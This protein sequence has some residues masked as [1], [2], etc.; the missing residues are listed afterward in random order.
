MRRPW[1]RLRYSDV[2][3]KAVYLDRRR[4]MAGAA[5]LAAAAR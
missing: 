5:G 2:T 4:L 3:P 1:N